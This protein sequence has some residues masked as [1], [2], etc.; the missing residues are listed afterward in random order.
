[1][2]AYAAIKDPH[3]KHVQEGD[4]T[5]MAKAEYARTKIKRKPIFPA[6]FR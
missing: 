1:M 6:W 3:G 2:V 4:A 5:M